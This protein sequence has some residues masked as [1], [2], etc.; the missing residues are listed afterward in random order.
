[1]ILLFFLLLLLSIFFININCTS[2]RSINYNNRI[3]Q[4]NENSDIKQCKTGRYVYDNECHVYNQGIG[5]SLNQIKFLIL[6]KNIFQLQ[7][8]PDPRCFNS[9]EHQTYLYNELG[10]NYNLNCSSDYILD[11]ANKDNIIKY[12]IQILK[13]DMV[14]FKQ[15]CSLVGNENNKIDLTKTEFIRGGLFYET[16][17][18][19]MK[20]NYI[21]KTNIKPVV[22]TINKPIYQLNIEDYKCTRSFIYEHYFQ[23]FNNQQRVINFDKNKINLAYHFRYG[24]T[25]KDD[26]GFASNP[27]YDGE[28]RRFPL[29][30]GIKLIK[31]L[32]SDNSN[33][34]LSECQI[35]FFSEGENTIFADFVA[36]FPSAI[37]VLGNKDTVLKD[38]DHMAHSD[39]F[40]GGP[41]SFST[42]GNISLCIL[43]LSVCKVCSIYLLLIA[44]ALNMN[45]V[46]VQTKINRDDEGIDNSI[47][48]MEIMNGNL[49]NFNKAICNNE[50]YSNI[51]P[52]K[53]K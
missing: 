41:G 38:L 8:I 23:R 20:S 46:I 6:V 11:E 10:W 45:G 34:K 42:L 29:E 49:D 5:S 40:M 44:A 19:I 52:V 27:D 15:I 25:S 32:I 33:L 12:T 16:Q 37:M 18:A 7:I 9:E 22:F 51:K 50:L 30:F 17:V 43:Y 53:C 35:Y 48:R 21:S 31:N 1:M 24:D 14:E 26:N 28:T 13:F 39:I 4:N 47:N 3:L 2:L 36:A